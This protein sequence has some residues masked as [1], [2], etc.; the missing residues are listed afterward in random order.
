MT[1]KVISVLLAIVCLSFSLSISSLAADDMPMQKQ[2]T[3]TFNEYQVLKTL[4]REYLEMKEHSTLGNSKFS[5]MSQEDINMIENYQDYFS[6]KVEM[7][8]S[9]TDEELASMGYTEKQISTI[10]NYDGSE[11]SMSSLSSDCKVTTKLTSY[12]NS[13][14]G[15]SA[16]ILTWFN[17]S[18][19]HSNFFN[20]IFAVVWSA[21]FN[22]TTTSGYVKYKNPKTTH[23]KTYNH[24]P[25][26]KG[27]YGSYIKFPKCKTITHQGT[28]Y[29]TGGSMTI[30]LRA[31]GNIKDF[32]AYSE[33]GYTSLNISPSVSYPGALSIAF[34]S[35][36]SCIASDRTNNLK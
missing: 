19:V 13:A 31:N 32:T 7:L 12:S 23:I 36:T 9:W 2:F 5:T 28:F 16:T 35:G 26:I 30:N 24:K 4:N 18:G 29:V 3:K 25:G 34:S 10:R 22:A 17:W 1:K 21:P 11:A 33:Y 8:Q 27:L 14:S 6:E 15:S 20:D